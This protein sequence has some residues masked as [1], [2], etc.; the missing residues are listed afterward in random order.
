MLGPARSADMA[1]DQ[2]IVGWIGE[3]H[4]GAFT[5]T[6]SDSSLETLD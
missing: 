3:H 6:A 2:D 5:V 1:G 4:L